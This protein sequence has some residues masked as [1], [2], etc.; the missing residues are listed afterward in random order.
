MKVTCS[1]CLTV[2]NITEDKL[3]K[4]VSKTSCRKC[5]AR[6]EIRRSPGI[7]SI[8]PLLDDVEMLAPPK[9]LNDIIDQAIP[10]R[11]LDDERTLLDEART[12]QPRPEVNT[13]LA[14]GPNPTFKDVLSNESN[15]DLDSLTAHTIPSIRAL[16]EQE[17]LKSE[18]PD[19]KQTGSSTVEPQKPK[20]EPKIV[21][22]PNIVQDVSGELEFRFDWVV[23]F[24][25]NLLTTVGIVLMISFHAT[26]K[27]MWA[28]FVAL[29]GVILS[30]LLAVSSQFGLK[31]GNVLACVLG[32]II[33]VL[34]I[35]VLNSSMN[36]GLF[37]L[38]AP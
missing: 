21:S 36:L 26:E 2:Y 23:S 34:L 6:I 16:S 30:V 9:S 38:P 19:L 12:E 35:Y 5:G 7:P 18:T 3:Q 25:A 4:E 15:S 24:C 22:K 32:A 8:K 10:K 1:Q 29:L 11:I 31:E 28:S 17:D 33:C 20:P 13:N 37:T 27:F 14:F